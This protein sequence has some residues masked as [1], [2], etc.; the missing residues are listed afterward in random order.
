MTTNFFGWIRLVGTTQTLQIGVISKIFTLYKYKVKAYCHVVRKI[1]SVFLFY[2]KI[3]VHMG[4]GALCCKR[5]ANQNPCHYGCERGDKGWCSF[6]TGKQWKEA[7]CENKK[8]I[9]CKK[10][11]KHQGNM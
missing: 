7:T 5:P 1:T 10:P 3:R 6:L 9:V 11:L 2:L 4:K 8:R